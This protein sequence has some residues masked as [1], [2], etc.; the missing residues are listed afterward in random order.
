MP[1]R[2]ILLNE[3][4]AIANHIATL[5]V[6]GAWRYDGGALGWNGTIITGIDSQ[7]ITGLQGIYI[8]DFS[9]ASTYEIRIIDTNGSE[10]KISPFRVNPGI[11]SSTIEPAS[12]HAKIYCN[13]S[14][15]GSTLCPDTTPTLT[16]NNV[17]A[18]LIAQLPSIP[19]VANGTDTYTL[20]LKVRDT[21]GNRVENGTM[22]LK[23][24]TTVKNI[25]TDPLGGIDNINYGPSFDGDAFL[26]PE[27]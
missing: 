6:S 18:T 12:F 15:S 7:A 1:L 20:T 10:T 8:A 14:G 25:Q 4:D 22:R 17:S 5:S 9:L 13:G 23:Y 19:V 2:P 24:R 26:S 21:Y 11:P 16:D 3:T 27:L